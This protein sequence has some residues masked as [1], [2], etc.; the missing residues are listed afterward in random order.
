MTKDQI[1]AKVKVLASDTLRLIDG[2][3][4]DD[5][6]VYVGYEEM[7]AIRYMGFHYSI[8]YN[9]D[10]LDREYFCGCR[11]IGVQLNSHFHVAR[12]DKC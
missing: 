4:S 2:L 7:R 3:G 9:R 1:E 8:D 6:I 10:K 12:A 11:L 5:C